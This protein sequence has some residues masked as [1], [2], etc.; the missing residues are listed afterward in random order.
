MVFGW[1]VEKDVETEKFTSAGGRRIL[2]VYHY[3]N[4]AK[5]QTTR[6]DIFH[7]ETTQHGKLKPFAKS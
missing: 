6:K 2:F 1:R 5:Q 7:A 4:I 3:P